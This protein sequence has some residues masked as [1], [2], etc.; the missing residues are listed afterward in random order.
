MITSA[1]D[2]I[3]RIEPTSCLQKVVEAKEGPVAPKGVALVAKGV[4]TVPEVDPDPRLQD[5]QQQQDPR[6]IVLPLENMSLII[7]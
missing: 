5:L 3:A 2:T 4:A 1:T 7:M 6:E